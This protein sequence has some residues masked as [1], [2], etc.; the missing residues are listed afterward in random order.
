MKSKKP[1]RHLCNSISH[2]G[3]IFILSLYLIFNILTSQ[4]ISP[5]YFN[6][7]NGNKIMAVIGYLE[8]L[9]LYPLFSAE[10]QKYRHVY[11][12]KIDD[13]VFASEREQKN[14]IHKYEQALQKNP[15]SVTALYNLS[16]L[17]GESG[18]QQKAEKY[19][20]LAKDLDPGIN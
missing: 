18:E 10:L 2:A 15:D 4:I 9:R 3:L 11:G 12:T 13:F 8:K 6:L 20:K 17:Y 5:L 7:I 19:L 1:R 16:L 14:I